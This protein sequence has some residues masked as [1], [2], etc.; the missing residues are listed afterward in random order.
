MFLSYLLS[1]ISSPLF[2]LGLVWALVS[3]IVGLLLGRWFKVQRELDQRDEA[4]SKSYWEH[5]G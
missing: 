2:K 4:Y 3:I 1:L 5:K